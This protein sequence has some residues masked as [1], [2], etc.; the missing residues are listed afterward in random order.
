METLHTRLT[1]LFNN[2]LENLRI[3]NNQQ[4]CFNRKSKG[5][6]FDK[7]KNKYQAKIC[8]NQN[9]IHLGMF[10]TEEEAQQAY[11]NAKQ[12]YHQF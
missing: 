1:L 9:Q 6:Y 4:N 11:L 2:N 8:I 7:R 3:V 10:D 12:I 5:F